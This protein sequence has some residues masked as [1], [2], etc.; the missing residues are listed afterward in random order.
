MAEGLQISRNVMIPLREIEFTAIRAQGPGGQNVNK[1]ASAIHLRFD[2][3]SS[4]LPAFYKERL[5]VYQDQRI[6]N[7]AVVVIKAQSHRTQELNKESALARLLELIRSATVT[8]RKRLATKPSRAAKAR[9]MDG[10]NKRG[11][12]KQQRRRPAFD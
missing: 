10:K 9:R 1:V 6:S 2:I 5:A 3:A 4:S 7:D 8:Q 12:L 11:Q